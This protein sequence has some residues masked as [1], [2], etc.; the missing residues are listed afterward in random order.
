MTIGARMRSGPFEYGDKVQMTS[1][2]KKIYTIKLKAGDRF[3]TDK[4]YILHDDIVGKD[5]GTILENTSGV[6]YLALRPL[7]SDYV[8]S[9][10]RGATVIYPKDAGQIITMGDI[11]PGAKVV[12]AGVGTG[13]L[14]LSLLRAVGEEGKVYSFELRDEFATIAAANIKNFFGQEH[15][16]WSLTM[17]DLAEKLNETVEDASID[18]I[19]LDMLAPWECVEACLQ[20]LRPG[21]VFIVYVATVTQLSRVVEQMRSTRRFTEPVCTESM[22]RGWHVDG[23]A[24]RP[25]HRMVAHTA[26]LVQARKMADGFEP[27]PQKKRQSKSEYSDADVTAWTPDAVGILGASDR[28]LRRLV[29]KIE[30]EDQNL[31]KEEN[32]GN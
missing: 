31:K 3:N 18:R 6:L 10:P 20:A 30:T 27:L 13:A 32:D 12:E 7:L 15:P 14:T 24:V 21:G 9:M 29:R 19:V 11:Y 5:E 16:A 2:K 25:D 26:F 1:Q 17:G 4:G 22:V 8:L 28:K 23:L